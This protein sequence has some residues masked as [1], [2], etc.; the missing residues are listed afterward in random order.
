MTMEIDIDGKDISQTCSIG[1]LDNTAIT[2]PDS[3]EII[4][5]KCG[6]VISG[7]IEDITHLERRASV[8]TLEVDRRPNTGAPSSLARHDRGLATLIGRPDKDADG[9]KIVILHVLP[10]KD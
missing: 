3:G 9:H 10:L 1:N 4:C 6:M 2:D 5:N 7:K 8:S